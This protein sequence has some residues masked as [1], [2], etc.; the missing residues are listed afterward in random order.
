MVYIHD[1]VT[2][3]PHMSSCFESG[4]WENNGKS[5]ACSVLIVSKNIRKQSPLNLKIRSIPF[6]KFLNPIKIEQ[7]TAFSAC[8]ILGPIL[9]LYT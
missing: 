5:L 3:C 7:P 4:L 8:T 9:M 2:P 6:L 1:N